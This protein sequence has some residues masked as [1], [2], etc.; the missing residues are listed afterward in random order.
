MIKRPIFIFLTETGKKLTVTQKIEDE[1][2]GAKPPD[3]VE[4]SMISSERSEPALCK[5]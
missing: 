4:R 1:V 3:E 5:S 2:E